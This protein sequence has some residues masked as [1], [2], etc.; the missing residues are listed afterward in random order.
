MIIGAN[1]TSPRHVPIIRELTR[2]GDVSF[3]EVMIDN[4]IHLSPEELT[5]AF[6][7]I[8][9]AFHV[10]NS[11]F[12]T[13]DDA[14]LKTLAARLKTFIRELRPLYV[15][16][17]LAV[18]THGARRFPFPQEI[19]YTREGAA[20]LDRAKL[21]QDMIG[22]MLHFENYPSILD[23]G[24]AQPEFLDS[25]TRHGSGLL[26]DLSNAVV[27][28]ENCR[29][30]LEAWTPLVARSAHF[31]AAGYRTA[32]T[33]PPFVQDSHDGPLSNETLALLRRCKPFLAGRESSLC[34]ER[35][36]NINVENWSADAV[37]A[38]EALA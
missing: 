15:S 13:R 29:L 18:F 33:V 34:I 10:M 8:P 21:W 14:E 17:H 27:A 30:P 35:D 25:L 26:L 4:F 3:V 23:L 22:T 5:K 6:P 1:W 16:D 12:I 24:K 7:G 38:R 31:H 9:L 11:H 2:R 36:A 37:A 20:A 19:D 32:D 28:Y